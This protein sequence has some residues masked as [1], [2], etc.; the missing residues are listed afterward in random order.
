MLPASHEQLSQVENQKH[1][2]PARKW[3]RESFLSTDAVTAFVRLIVRICSALPLDAVSY[4]I[5][6]TTNVLEK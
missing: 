2:S 1:Y 6:T 3:V 5:P 4:I